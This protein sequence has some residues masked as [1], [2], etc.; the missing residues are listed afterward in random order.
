MTPTNH[1]FSVHASPT[2]DTLH[3]DALDAERRDE[4][5]EH[6]RSMADVAKEGFGIELDGSRASLEGL[7]QVLAECAEH[8]AQAGI[9]VASEQSQLLIVMAGAYLGEVFRQA[10][11]GQWYTLRSAGLD[12]GQLCMR[13]GGDTPAVLL[14][15]T[16]VVRRLTEGPEFNV[17]H[18]AQ[19]AWTIAD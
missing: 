17:W 19:A 8:M 18:Y 3:F 13:T 15:L 7:E 10:M 16:R 12:D 9:S 14:P 2:T 11:G 4:L 5:A 6:A 1:P